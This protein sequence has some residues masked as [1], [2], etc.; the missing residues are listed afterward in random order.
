M[1]LLRYGDAGAEKPGMLDADGTLRDLSGV[2]S[3]IAGDV[4][5]DEGLA[6]LR[7]ID[8]ASLPKV[9]GNPRLGPCVGNIGK[10][11]CIGLNYSDHAAETGAAIPE[12]PILF[13]K[14]NSAIVGPN[15]MVMKP[16]GSTHTDW[17]VELGVVIGKAAKYVSKEDALDY[18]AGYCVIND[19]SERHYQSQLTGQWTKG[20]SCD[21]F[22]PTGPWLVTRDEVADPQ[23]LAMYLDVN[24]KRM[25]TG[26]TNTMIF[27]VAEIIEH[28]SGLFTL[29][30]G[31]V[32]STGTP[33][34]V[35]MGIKPTPVYLEKGDVMELGIDGLGVQRQEVGQDA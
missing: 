28:L 30:P 25:Q 9:D 3:D 20:K 6:K 33:P 14:A 29:Q 8:P 35:G 19:V 22:G 32:I 21:T 34:G 2:V 12:H 17:E 5:S 7:D 26:N 31:D 23:A 11:C 27:T 18:V 13:M 4:L 10:F 16:R 24:G 15:D 1:K